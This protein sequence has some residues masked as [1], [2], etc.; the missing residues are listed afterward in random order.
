MWLRGWAAIGLL[1]AG[2]LA[3]IRGQTA[4]PAAAAKPDWSPQSRHGWIT[5]WRVVSVGP[6]RAVSI[7]SLSP[8][9]RSQT[10]GSFGQTAGSFGQSAGNTGQ[11][12]GSFGQSAGNTGKAAGSVGQ[13]A[14]SFGVSTAA[15]ASAAAASNGTNAIAPKDDS[16]LTRL[17][18][19]LE[20]GHGGLT[21]LDVAVEEVGIDEL[22]T[23]LDA[24][25]GTADAPDVLVGTPL[26][27][28]WSDQNS[29]LVRRYGL[30][31]LGAVNPIP[32]TEAG[33]YAP[34]R[35]E[36]SILVRAPHPRSARE[37]IKW[38]SDRSSYTNRP[39]PPLSTDTPSLLARAA[40][41]S[42]LFGGDIGAAA[43]RQMADFNPRI[44]Q[45][46]A[47]AVYG[48]G[49]LDGLKV[50][51]TWSPVSAND[52]FAVVELHAVME[53]KAAFGVAHAVA[54]LRLDEAGQWKILQLTPNLAVEQ[55]QVAA[56]HLFGFATRVR[57]EEVAQV[58]SASLAAPLDGD[59]R[60]PVPEFWWDNMGNGTLEVVEWQKRAGNGWTGSNLYFVP[61]DA[62]HLRTRTTGRFADAAGLY[63]WRVW[64]LGRGGTSAISGWR[65]VNILGQ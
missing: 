29:G 2:S 54:V 57:R 56:E 42:V 51:M 47:M 21:F 25:A 18:R 12:S 6:P 45:Q 40:L 17:N 65:S 35:P 43:D 33:E 14:G 9:L 41:R 4:A 24:V 61:E 5:I 44:A 62:G 3:Q 7:A 49:L 53:S 37:F 64:S 16:S 19:D 36:A 23:Q 28:T 13:T 52:R 10:S 31:T 8:E 39:L 50:D 11:T 58:K 22:Q 32:Q 15:L 30:V 1:A 63:R 48:E 60:P 27:E 46:T 55:Q 59:N 34:R 38:L 20:D 26:P